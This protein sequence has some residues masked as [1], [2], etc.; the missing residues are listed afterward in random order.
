MILRNKVAYKLTPKTIES[1]IKYYKGIYYVDS[2][3][4]TFD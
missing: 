2:K 1:L 3:A 4:Y